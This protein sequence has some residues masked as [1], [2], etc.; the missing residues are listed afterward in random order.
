MTYS[1]IISP[2]AEK[3]FVKLANSEPNAY[4][5]A[6]NLLEELKT[7]PTTGT[8]HP[9]QL[10]GALNNVWSRRITRKHRLVYKIIDNKV[11]VLILSAFG[12]YSDK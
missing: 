6:K 4:K 7:N 10:K 2:E 5:K 12:H 11:I 8:G 9:E 1:I 3:D